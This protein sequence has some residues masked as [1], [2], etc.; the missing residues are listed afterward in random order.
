MVSGSYF[1]S[2]ITRM[3]RKENFVRGKA[4][5]FPVNHET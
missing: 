3:L 5:S 1:N 4:G 2:R